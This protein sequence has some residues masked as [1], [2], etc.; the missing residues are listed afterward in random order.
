MGWAT[1]FDDTNQTI[2]L[3]CN[4]SLRTPELGRGLPVHWR[5]RRK[6]GPPGA[7]A[8]LVWGRSWTGISSPTQTHTHTTRPQ[9]GP[10]PSP[11]RSAHNPALR[12]PL[13]LRAG[14]D[15]RHG[16]PHGGHLGGGRRWVFSP[17]SA[18]VSARRRALSSSGGPAAHP[19]QRSR[20]QG[21]CTPA[22]AG[23]G[24]ESDAGRRAGRALPAAAEGAARRGAEL[25]RRRR[26]RGDRGARSFVPATAESKAG[27]GQGETLKH[28]LRPTP[29]RTVPSLRG[30]VVSYQSPP[31]PVIGPP[32]GFSSSSLSECFFRSLKSWP[33]RKGFSDSCV[34]E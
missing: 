9:A 18:P 20:G 19:G 23:R 28:L 34:L 14:A 30:Q 26:G 2:T 5:C 33:E 13:T 22:A 15:L 4:A 16:P 21:P 7:T 3:R 17:D 29:R 8:R 11:T 1:A 12:L 27:E 10:E 25:G 32:L 6:K 24:D 31:P